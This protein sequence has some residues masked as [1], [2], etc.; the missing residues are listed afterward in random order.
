MRIGILTYHYALNCG[1]V[2]QGF[3]LQKYLEEEG[4]IVEFIN[5]ENEYVNLAYKLFRFDNY[6]I[7][8][9]IKC[10]KRIQ[11]EI[12]KINRYPKFKKSIKENLKI[13]NRVQRPEDY[14]LSSYDI[15]IIGSDQLWNKSITDGYDFF[16]CSKFKKRDGQKVIGYAISMNKPSLNNDEREEMIKI[17][18][19]F[20]KLSVR[21]STSVSL[22]QPLT[23][24]TVELVIDPTFLLSK[25]QWMEFTKPVKE[26]GY[27]CCYPVLNQ[28]IVKAR[29]RQI[30]KSEKKK[31]VILEPVADCIA[32]S[33]GKKINTP[34]E[35]L[36]YIANADMVLTSSFH[37]T[38]FSLIMKKD[39]YL[40]GD[41]KSNVRMKNFLGDLGL[42]GRIIPIEQDININDHIDY[43]AVD[44][45][46][47]KMINKSKDFLKD[48]INS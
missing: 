35:F 29:A 39:F 25:N 28:D 2:L 42:Q 43:I 45:K 5:Y 17:M 38:A 4:H 13:G 19:N 16:Y 21:E 47:N 44:N 10:L 15:I 23:L 1:A 33:D 41:D 18:A 36:S 6:I 9:P 30:A 11:N 40:L 24:K 3:S 31:L 32:F 48:S 20:D 7:T 12:V 46:L 37:G 8:E 26:I 22:L 27:I 14:D 34:F